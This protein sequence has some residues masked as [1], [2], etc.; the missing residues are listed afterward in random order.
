[1]KNLGN[2]TFIKVIVRIYQIQV[3]QR[4]LKKTL[5]CRAKVQKFFQLK[6]RNIQLKAKATKQI[7]VH[8]KRPGQKLTQGQKRVLNL[9]VQGPLNLDQ[10]LMTHQKDFLQKENLLN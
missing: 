8:L 10:M 3:D 7:A 1:M 4:D 9:K 5:R 2:L 6:I